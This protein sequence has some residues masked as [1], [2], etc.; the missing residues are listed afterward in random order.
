MGNII[1]QFA[2]TEGYVPRLLSLVTPLSERDAG[3]IV[4]VF[5]AFSNKIDVLE[6]VAGNHGDNTWQRIILSYYKGRLKE[7]NSIRNK[8]GHAAL[9]SGE[10]AD[11]TLLPYFAD[12]NNTAKFEPLS[13]KSIQKDLDRILRINGE[14][15][16][17][18]MLSR[19]PKNLCKTA[20][21]MHPADI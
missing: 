13:L 15:D 14:L 5:R 12:R 11:L 16:E 2:I 7:A 21:T 1:A 19:V 9:A 8:Y 17:L 3:A 10:G 4:S 18:L 20:Y 6:A